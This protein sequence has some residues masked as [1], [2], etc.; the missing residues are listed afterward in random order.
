MLAYGLCGV[1]DDGPVSIFLP[2]A[3][4][5]EAKS[6]IWFRDEFAFGN[7]TIPESQSVLPDRPRLIQ[8][9]TAA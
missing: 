7:R 9:L 5:V 4:G 8:T 6:E 2:G 3:N 1:G